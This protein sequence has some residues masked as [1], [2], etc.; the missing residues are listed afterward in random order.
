MFGQFQLLL[1]NLLTTNS[2]LFGFFSTFSLHF[3]S[4]SFD[5]RWQQR[6]FFLFYSKML[7]WWILCFFFLFSISRDIFLAEHQNTRKTPCKWWQ[8]QW[9]TKNNKN[10]LFNF[11]ILLLFFFCEY[12]HRFSHL[13]L[14]SLLHI[15]FSLIKFHHT[16]KFPLLLKWEKF[17]FYWMVDFK[18]DIFHYYLLRIFD[19]LSWTRIQ[20]GKFD[21]NCFL[22]RIKIKRKNFS[23]KILIISCN[24]WIFA[25][26]MTQF[27]VFFFVFW[28]FCKKFSLTWNFNR[29][30]MKKVIHQ[31]RMELLYFFFCFHAKCLLNTQQYNKNIKT[32]ENKIQETGGTKNQNKI[33]VKDSFSFHLKLGARRQI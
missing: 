30:L 14:Q 23:R 26:M 16:K 22:C 3:V 32:D 6:F 4:C 25:F 11:D 33:K 29:I 12:N 18:I 1:K 17:V 8:N 28:L 5:H 13:I 10:S 21:I 19:G 15:F 9:K 20:P 7:G 24:N 27:L 31:W 2:T